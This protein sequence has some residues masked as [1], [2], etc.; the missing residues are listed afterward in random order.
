MKSDLD[1][2]R[3]RATDLL[4]VARSHGAQLK[5][6]SGEWIGP[7]PACG[8]SDRFSVNTKA[9]L[10][11]CRG[12]GGGDVIDLEMH[13][14]G[15]TFVDAVRALI[16]DEQQHGQR[17]PTPEETAS[18]L[19]R[20]K[21]RLHEAAAEAEKNA[22]RAAEI[23]ARL[24]PVIGTPGEAYLRDVRGTDVN[25][26]AIRRALMDVETLGWSEQVY[27]HQ[28]N[29]DEPFHELNGQ[30]RGAIVAILTDPVT[31]E[32]TGGI[33]RTF[34][35]QGQKIGKAMSLGGA[36]RPG[37]I[38]LTPDDE[39]LTGLHIAEGL[40]TALS[41]MMVGFLPMWATGSTS[42][43][44]KLPVLDGIECVTILADNDENGAGEKAAIK[45]GLRW[46]AAG[47][48][49]RVLETPEPGDLNDLVRRA[50]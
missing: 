50:V 10:W 7:S 40:E 9:R 19:A 1:V 22:R 13:L 25:H 45:V 30:Y 6:P 21:Q 31:A 3:A 17:K 2:A 26:W 24:Q 41:A 32:R 39:A 27:F 15:S 38:R 16:G 14:A 35:H 20:E 44:A 4:D 46:R 18:R 37:I 8:G 12:F 5:E 42:Q 43:M 34:V 33:T 47:R 29:P 23:I 36:G 48:K 49:V 11:N 28:L